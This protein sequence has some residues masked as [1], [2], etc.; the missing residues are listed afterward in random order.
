MA[1]SRRPRSAPPRGNAGSPYPLADLFGEPRPL[2]LAGGVYMVAPLRVRDLAALGAFAMRDAPSPDPIEVARGLMAGEDVPPE[3]LA[4]AFRAAQDFANH[5]PPDLGTPAYR[6]ATANAEGLT[7][8]AFVALRRHNPGFG[9][10]DAAALVAAMLASDPGGFARLNARAFGAHPVRRFLGL[11]GGD[12]DG[13]E[14]QSP[15][16]WPRLI[17]TLADAKG[18]T[19]EEIGE[20]ALPAFWSALRRGEAPGLDYTQVKRPDESLMDLSRR[21]RR[22]LGLG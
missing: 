14:G 7:W 21:V 6:E 17:D 1:C 18:W 16:D 5:P 11:I 8:F 10:D 15:P 19:Y 12:G 13:G 4:V 3:A 2:G 20:M 9:I 22:M